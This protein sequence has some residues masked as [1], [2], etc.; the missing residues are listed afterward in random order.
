MME[1]VWNGQPLA[2]EPGSTLEDILRAHPVVTDTCVIAALVNNQ[3]RE[4]TYAPDA[5]DVVVTLDLHHPDGWRIYERSLA[6]IF[7]QAARACYPGARV[8]IE[9]SLSRGLYCRVAGETPVG[10][11]GVRR[12]SHEMQR[13]ISEDRPIR[14]MEV[15][16]QEAVAH[17][18]ALGMTDKVRLLAY[19]KGEGFHFYESGG[20]KEY[21]Y[22]Y[23]APSTGYIQ[24]YR[25]HA[26]MPGMVLLPPPAAD[27]AGPIEFVSQP[28]LAA[29]FRQAERWG[30]MMGVSNAA[31]LNDLVAKGDAGEFIRI[32]EALHEKSIAQIADQICQD[33]N[34]R[35]IL[36]AGPSS[37]GKT[38]FAQRL[39]IQLKVN[40]Q[41][42]VTISL[43]NYYLDR[44]KCPRDQYGQYDFE[45][46]QAID[47]AQFNEDLTRLLQGEAVRLPRFDFAKGRQ[48]DSGVTLQLGERQPI[49]VE[50][51]HGLNESLT[52]MI[53]REMKFKIYIS[54][55]T[56]L[57]LDDQNRIPSTD[58]RLIR[59]IVRDH[60]FRNTTAEG[61]L[62]LWSSVRRGEERYIFPYQE[63]ADVMFNSSLTYELAVLA[64]YIAPLLEGFDHDHSF[65][66]EVN[67]LR[68][69]IQY[70]QPVSQALEQEIPR[71][72]ILR[73][74][75]GGS[76]FAH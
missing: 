58:D 21:M 50:G 10:I 49:V 27:P 34:R 28:K 2:V 9:H 42:P 23:M 25:L 75:I 6:Y 22:G 14:R 65:Y 64:R 11:Q 62:K 59:R 63:Q 33:P 29:V 31:D 73:E 30:E 8:L 66:P 56:Q 46:I 44:D 60:Q 24:R 52:A 57:N 17:Y 12:I 45:S 5:F 16:R 40:G 41:R 36:I 19:R 55:L 61:T 48:V 4:L 35:L 69:F 43:D 32:N 74:F 67:R 53:P 70:F 38:T 54:C 20:M 47:I 7:V 1:I 72:S 15:T 18:Q 76:S 71:T 39:G 26:Y 68:K 3:L 37:S 13:I 51:I